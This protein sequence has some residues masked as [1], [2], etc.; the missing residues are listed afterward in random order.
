MTARW[1]K[2]RHLRR[3]R[4]RRPFVRWSVGLLV[5][6]ASLSWLVGGFG[7]ADWGSPRRLANLQRFLGEVRPWPVQEG[8]WDTA[9]VLAW[10]A[11]LW[12][13]AGAEALTATLAIGLAAMAL[14]AVAGALVSLP[15]ARTFARPRPFLPGGRPPS[16]ARRLAWQVVVGATRLVLIFLRSVPEYVWAFLLLALL[17]PTAWPMVLALALHNTGIL[18]KLGAEVIE[19]TGAAAPGALRGLGA[20]RWQVASASL[21][22]LALPR[23]LLYVFY[24]WETCVREAT[25]LG[26]LGMSSLGYWIM[27]SRARNHYDDLLYFVLLAAVLVVA[28]DVV[29]ALSRRALRRA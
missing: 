20:T 22:P 19:N 10:S 8:G 2:V 26:M 13:R 27:D 25:V 5:T 9:A 28:G 29:S 24:R 7:A 1:E 23:Y 21:L 6:M 15:A 11:D 17:G 12:D 14:A 18:G 4:P 16:R 3:E